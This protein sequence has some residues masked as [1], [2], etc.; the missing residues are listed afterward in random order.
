MNRNVEGRSCTQHEG[1]AVLFEAIEPGAQFVA[2]DSEIRETVAPLA[3][4]D[5]FDGDVGLC[6][7]CGDEDAGNCGALRIEHAAADRRLVDGFLCRSTAGKGEAD[8]HQRD[9]PAEPG[10][11]VRI[12][13]AIRRPAVRHDV[14]V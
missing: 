12:L 14:A 6:L 2:A 7:T 4:G 8:A 5:R 1:A 11:H 13:S 3:V 10:V 9:E